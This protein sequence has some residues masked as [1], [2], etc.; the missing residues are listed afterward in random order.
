M[1]V[2]THIQPLTNNLKTPKKLNGIHVETITK[3]ANIQEIEANEAEYEKEKRM[4]ELRFFL[5]KDKCDRSGEVI[6]IQC[7]LFPTGIL[8][9]LSYLGFQRF[10]YNFEKSIIVRVKDNIVEE[11][12]Q[13]HVIDAFFQFIKNELPEIIYT[14]L[15]NE[16]NKELL[17]D[18]VLRSL[19]NYFSDIM[20]YRLKTEEEFDFNCDTAT[21][22]FFYYQNGFVV[23]TKEGF[24]LKPYSELKKKIWKSQILARNFKV[25]DTK[26]ADAAKCALFINYIAGNY[27]ENGKERDPD[28]AK[29]LRRVIGYLMHRYFEGKLKSVILTDSREGDDDGGR[30]GKSLMMKFVGWMMNANNDSKSFVDIDAK[31]FDPL[32]AHKWQLL[33][34]NTQCVHMNDVRKN[35]PLEFIYNAILEGITVQKKND[36][37]FVIKS[38]IALSTNKTIR[39]TGASA[40]DRVFEF[41]MSNYF[42]EKKSPQQEFKEW[43]GSDW[44]VERWYEFDNFMLQSISMYLAKGLPIARNFNLEERKFKDETSSDFVQFIS[45]I[46]IDGHTRKKKE[47]YA[48]FRLEYSDWDNAKFTMNR[49]TAWMKAFNNHNPE[50]EI[51]EVRNRIEKDYDLTFIKKEAEKKRAEAEKAKTEAVR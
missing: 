13:K 35:F 3:T 45:E 16:Y 43:F 18:K 10:D 14:P 23:A 25:I 34:V 4:N 26:K 28:R 41:Q 36:K 30:S 27:C 47:L 2:Q 50:W 40:Q 38:K 48:T 21:E 22:S 37:P 51:Q 12:S 31:E 46:L 44:G 8:K 39:T 29:D 1:N 42:S 32:Y 5:L 7:T 20:L 49:F 15:N 6:E 19:S 33:E 11:V 17:K 24:E 9:V